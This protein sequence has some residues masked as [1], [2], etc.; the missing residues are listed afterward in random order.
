MPQAE[1]LLRSST[2]PRRPFL[3]GDKKNKYCRQYKKW[4]FPFFPPRFLKSGQPSRADTAKTQKRVVGE[5]LV[6][7]SPI[8][9]GGIRATKLL[10][11]LERGSFGGSGGVLGRKPIFF[12]PILLPFACGERGT[13]ELATLSPRRTGFF[14][15][16][17]GRGG[18][19][20]NFFFSSD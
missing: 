2:V 14:R 12:V 9:S 5:F 19:R 13:T 8:G 3:D 10:R 1:G 4:F 7:F 20:K 6:F 18:G 15:Q 16:I 11:K 17:G